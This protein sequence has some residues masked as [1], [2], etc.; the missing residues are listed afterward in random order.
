MPFDPNGA[1]FWKGY[2]HLFYIFQRGDGTH[3]WGHASSVDLVHWRHHR[4]GLDV[5][6]RDPDRGIFSG[7]AFL[8][9]KGTPTILY[10]GVGIGNA[11]AR[12]GAHRAWLW[13]TQN[14]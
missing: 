10:H 6:P 11:I 4:T 5:A 9:R 3:C 14:A 12:R 7:N 13:R 1:I 8:D 2:Y